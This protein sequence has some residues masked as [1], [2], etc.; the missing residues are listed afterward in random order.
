MKIGLISDV[1]A[2][3]PALETVLDDMPT[4]DRIYCAGDVVG[5][6]PWPAD[7]VERVRDVAAATVRGNHDRTVETP[8]RYRA[9]R[10]AEAG[11]ER[12]KASLSADQRD[13]IGDLPRTETF[14]GDRYL[15]AHSHPAAER[16]DAYVYP[17]DFPTLDR[18]MG[19]YD[20]I[21]LGHTHVQGVRE[22]AGGFVC[23]PGSVGQPRD[24]DPRAGY[25]VLDTTADGADAVETHRVEYD[26]D[27]VAE[28]VH[29]ADLPDLTA[30]RLYEGE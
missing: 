3:L 27:R 15:L 9:N 8:E 22:V 2:N 13:W 28:A 29:E 19:E 14:G 26:I 30:E 1:H 7:C 20:G 17:D 5:Y 11:L 21:V 4:V 24:G 10:M 25:A 18:H 6:N 12:A 16:E 23:N